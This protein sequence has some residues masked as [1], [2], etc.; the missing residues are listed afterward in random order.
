M[1]M[2]RGVGS[3]R[4]RS[5]MLWCCQVCR[6]HVHYG[7]ILVPTNAKTAGSR[8]R[9]A[10]L[11]RG[12][13][14]AARAN[15]GGSVDLDHAPG[16]DADAAMRAALEIAPM[17]SMALRRMNLDDVFVELVGKS[18]GEHKKGARIDA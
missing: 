12:I 13:A 14:T 3:T 10:A 16:T 8:G 6:S 1:R 18:D 7:Q 17:R 15:D 5:A 4:G 2:G 11:A 9:V